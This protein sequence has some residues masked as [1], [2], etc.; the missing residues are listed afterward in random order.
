MG[1]RSEVAYTI[2]FTSDH[3]ENNRQS[4][5]TFLAEAK[6][7]AATAPCFTEE[8][9]Q[10]SEFEVDEKRF[11]INFNAEGV[12]WY[13]SYEDVKCHE[14][15]IDLAAEWVNDEDNNSSIAYVFVRIGEQND[16]IEEKEGGDYDYDWIQVNRSISRDW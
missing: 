9:G 11:R 4:F 1:Y 3:D 6:S 15:L 7:K 13:E 8:T 14:A 16:D 12:K 5:F 2:R 10:W